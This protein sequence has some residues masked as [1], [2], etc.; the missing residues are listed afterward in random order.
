MQVFRIDYHPYGNTQQESAGIA[1]PVKFMDMLMWKNKLFRNFQGMLDRTHVIIGLNMEKTV[2]PLYL[3]S[4][5]LI[6]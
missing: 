3:K 5:I 1:F 2:K 4:K 6:I